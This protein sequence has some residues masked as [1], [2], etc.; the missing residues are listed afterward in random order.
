MMMVAYDSQIIS[1][2]ADRVYKK[3]NLIIIRYVVLGFMVGLL[4]FFLLGS[5]LERSHKPVYGG[6]FLPLLLLLFL[7]GFCTLVGLD[8]GRNKAFALKL[9]AQTAL[10]IVQIEENTRAAVA[11]ASKPTA[12]GPPA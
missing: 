2:F 1:Q 7:W 5:A 8:I 10:V 11:P 6:S 3:A 4:L 12:P 9:Q